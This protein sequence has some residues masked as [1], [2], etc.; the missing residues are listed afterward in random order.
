MTIAVQVFKCQGYLDIR[1][2]DLAVGLAG[3]DKPEQA[4]TKGTIAEAV[5][6]VSEEH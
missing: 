4:I 3:P 5:P 2:S 1:I 6:S